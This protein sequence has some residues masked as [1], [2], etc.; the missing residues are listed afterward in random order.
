MALIY[1]TNG[2]G[3]ESIIQ[4][5]N[6][7]SDESSFDRNRLTLHILKTSTRVTTTPLFV[8]IFSQIYFS[9]NLPERNG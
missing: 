4:I 7:T 2:D 8:L 6:L 3:N 9:K 1:V 5:E